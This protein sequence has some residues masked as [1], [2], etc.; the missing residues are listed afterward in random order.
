M[1][2]KALKSPI[3]EVVEYYNGARNVVAKTDD[4]EDAYKI[5]E[6]QIDQW[7]D[8][9]VARRAVLVERAK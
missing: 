5:R 4:A 1:A 8:V 6:W 9:Q 2:R 3:W 7:A